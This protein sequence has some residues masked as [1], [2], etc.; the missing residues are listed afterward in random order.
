M[1]EQKMMPKKNEPFRTIKKHELMQVILLANI[2]VP[3]LIK[4]EILFILFQI[5]VFCFFIWKNYRGNLYTLF[6]RG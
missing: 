5:F 1:L 2:I 3:L 6:V 4:T